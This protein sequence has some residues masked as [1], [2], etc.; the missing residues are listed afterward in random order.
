MAHIAGLGLVLGPALLGDV[1]AAEIQLA[2]P[3]RSTLQWHTVRHQ[4]HLQDPLIYFVG[5][6]ALSP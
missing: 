2:L 4:R 6:Q 1:H 5:V 3:C